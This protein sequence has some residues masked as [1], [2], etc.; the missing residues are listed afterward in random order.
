MGDGMYT[1]TGWIGQ[2]DTNSNLT[3]STT[4][5][6]TPTW[7]SI[8]AGSV[9]AGTAAWANPQWYFTPDFLKSLGDA[10]EQQKTEE[11]EKDIC[12]SGV[13]WDITSTRKNRIRRISVYLNNRVE[14]ALSLKKKKRIKISL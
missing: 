12:N 9:A 2:S 5:N 14:V 3:I 4:D 1:L 11:P 8:T 13:S 7:T 10:L 6:T